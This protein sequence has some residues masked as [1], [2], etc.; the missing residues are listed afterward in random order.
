MRAIVLLALFATAAHAEVPT[1]IVGK[2]TDKA[3]RPIESATVTAGA[4]T[5]MS[6]ANGIYRLVVPGPG[7]YDVD[8]SYADA[9]ET[10]TISV[11]TTV[12]TL[13]TKLDVD[14]EA[15]IVIHD[16]RPMVTRP[17]PANK[18]EHRIIP[19]Y[20]DAAIEHDAWE[21]A[22]LLLD[23]DADGV[24]QRLK[25]LHEPGHDLKAIAT[26]HAFGLKFEPGRD[27]Q[28]RPMPAL[29]LWHFEWPAYWWLV[30][31]EGVTTALTTQ[32]YSAS[33]PCKGSGPLY[34]TSM[35]KVYR[36][37]SG[38]DLHKGLTAKWIRR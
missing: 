34:M 38:P 2:L 37:C 21:N 36:D 6:N 25:F 3:G 35:H 13:D 24:V 4:A 23:V 16:P 31:M 17:K 14:S 7:T 8:F 9:Q 18:F 11:E 29:V 10:R 27:A 15:V 30:Q 5:V 26:K 1:Q 28:D 12:A 33:P 19:P 20:S 22:W 32:I